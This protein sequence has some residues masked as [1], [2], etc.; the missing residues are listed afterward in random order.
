VFSFNAELEQ[1][2]IV[3]GTE[4]ETAANRET[5]EAL[6]RAIIQKW[7]NITVPMKRDRDVTEAD[8]KAHHLLLIGRP[9][10]NALV[11]R[12]REALPVSFGSRSFTVRQEA[13]AHPDSAVIVAGENPVNKRFSMVVLAG[14]SAD[15]T[16]RTPDAL[17]QQRD[18]HGEVL[19]LPQGGQPR[20]L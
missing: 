14:L 17:F 1:S 5:A 11:Q 13:F 16:T 15:A 4:N 2:L 12:F 20:S 3:Y 19:L 8:C 9:D 6:Q 7:S 18:P 10:A